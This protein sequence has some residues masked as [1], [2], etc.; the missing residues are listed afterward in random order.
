M[1]WRFL[2]LCVK[3]SVLNLMAPSPSQLFTEY[4]RLAMDEIFLKPF[5]VRKV[6]MMSHE[7]SQL[8]VL[9]KDFFFLVVN[10]L[11]QGLELSL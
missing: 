8:Q 1:L 7:A 11:N 4:G 5:Q 6:M 2:F 10:V 9:N 3:Y